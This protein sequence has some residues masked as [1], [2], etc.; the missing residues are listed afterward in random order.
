MNQETLNRTAAKPAAKRPIR[1]TNHAPRVRKTE[2]SQ[3]ARYKGMLDKAPS[4]LILADLDYNIT[5]VN[6]SSLATLKSIERHLPVTADRVLGSNIDI[7]HKDPQRIRRLLADPR[8]LPHT[9]NVQIGPEMARLHVIPIYDADGRWDSVMLSWDLITEKLR[10]EEINK[11]NAEVIANFGGFIKELNHVSHQHDLG[12]IDDRIQEE[13]FTGELRE[14][15]AAVN[16]MVTGHIIVKKKAM[17]CVAEF[18]KGNFDAPLETFPRKK[19]FINQI[20]EQ[21]RGNLKALIA[22]TDS[23]V[24][25][26]LE[27]KLDTRA[28]ASRHQG[29]FQ[30]IV[31][32]INN[33]LDAV[34]GPLRVAARYVDLISKGEIPQP[35]SDTYHGDFNTLKNNLNHLIDAMN[36]VTA[37]A[38]KAA[39]GDL[40]INVELRS[41]EDKLMQALRAMMT[42]MRDLVTAAE[43][44]A[45]GDL[46]VTLELRSPEDSLM[47]ALQSMVE[48]ILGTVSEIR[49]IAHEVAAA[50]QSLSASS[51]QV[52][53]GASSQAASAEQ[54]SAAM[55]QIVSNI[56]QN[57][58]NALQTDKIASKSAKDAQESG[59]SVSEAVSAIK[60]IAD[61]ISIIE[62]IA[63]QT[64]LL[65]LNAAIEAARAG[66]HGKGFAVVAA[67][68]RKLAER[69]QK[70]AGEINQL[71][72]ATLKVSEKSGEMLDKL[73]PDIQRTA[74][75]VQEIS[76][77]SREQ[78]TGAEQINQALQQL[79]KVIQENASAADGMSSS[80]EE[81]S[82]QAQNL[83]SALSFFRTGDDG[84]RAPER[85]REPA[86]VRSSAAPKRSAVAERKA[87]PKKSLNKPGKGFSLRMTDGQD[88]GDESFERY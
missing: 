62:E 32:G 68:V 67:E 45:A 58:D 57:A 6:E 41:P 31:L 46:T 23:L 40:S 73:V 15:A 47:R 61:K 1:S 48:G 13:N 76:A 4:N 16:Q 9:A 27:G 17:A 36:G 83:V 84:G 50:S 43:R 53:K 14:A 80:T 30:S 20:I 87:A 74:E 56:K 37:T 85:P 26:A 19:A 33:T 34:I 25:S 2:N 64:N 54:A 79:E 35:I 21:V 7:F 88:E 81:L 65:A 52:S 8:N 18:G 11:N 77:A 66:E 78:D 51:D 72:S 29:G 55:E 12:E 86:V 22:D 5:Y 75:L 28:D 49:S 71:S 82:T 44:I 60:E 39:A 69:S 10:L 42:S 3:E 38:Q 63:R 24:K 59:K 70:A